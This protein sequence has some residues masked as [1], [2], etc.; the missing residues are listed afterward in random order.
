[1]RAKLIRDFIVKRTKGFVG[2]HQFFPD[3]NILGTVL[4]AFST[5]DTLGGEGRALL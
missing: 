1:M 2:F 3:G 5:A 4:F